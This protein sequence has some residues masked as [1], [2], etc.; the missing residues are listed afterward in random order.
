M[1]TIN[2]IMTKPELDR[3]Y[4]SLMSEEQYYEA[5]VRSIGGGFFA[6]SLKT[7]DLN[8]QYFNNLIHSN[9]D[10]LRH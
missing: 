6:F 7:S 3:L 5:I 9:N 2:T 1:T 10:R 8:G 4:K